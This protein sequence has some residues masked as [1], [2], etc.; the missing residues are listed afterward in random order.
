M[1]PTQ[2]I[3]LVGNEGLLELY[4]R[5]ASHNPEVVMRAL[6]EADERQKAFV[7]E[8]AAQDKQHELDLLRMQQ[9]PD[10]QKNANKYH[11]DRHREWRDTAVV[12]SGLIG[13]IG[14]LIGSVFVGASGVMLGFA[15]AALVGAA[16]SRFATKEYMRKP[17]QLKH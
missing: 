11:L 15:G 8:K 1:H 17:W 10:M 9:A 5:A 3:A 12:C 2:S 13:G 6:A 16:V 7:L 14:M 4:T